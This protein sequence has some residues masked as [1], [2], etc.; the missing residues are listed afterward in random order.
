MNRLSAFARLA[1]ANISGVNILGVVGA[2]SLAAFASACTFMLL[3]V[4]LVA[5]QLQPG[6]GDDGTAFTFVVGVFLFVCI[7]KSPV[8]FAIL[9][10]FMLPFYYIGRLL[11]CNNLLYLLLICTGLLVPLASICMWG[12]AVLAGSDEYMTP[13]NAF[14]TN[15]T[16]YVIAGLVFG[17]VFWRGLK[18]FRK[19]KPTAGLA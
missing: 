14:H 7:A 10:I 4:M 5:N 2:Y 12:L 15:K 16:L 8:L 17:A 6:S 3:R 18:M 9:F 11:R 1:F 19:S 13:A